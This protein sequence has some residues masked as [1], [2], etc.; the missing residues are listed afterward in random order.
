MFRLPRNNSLRRGFTLIEAI[1]SVALLVVLSGITVYGMIFHA[2]TAKSNLVR[3]RIAE[4]S[5]KFID[6]AQIAALDATI[7]RIDSGPAGAGT[8]LTIGKPDPDNVGSVIYKQY[9]YLDTDGNP[10]TINDN[11]I[12]E[13]DTNTPNAT[14]GK[15]LVEYCYPVTGTRIFTQDA[16]SLRPLFNINL[17]VGDR[18]FPA[19]NADNAF[20]GPGYQAF[21]IQTSIAQL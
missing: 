7:I 1:V 4:Q 13:R 12:V 15:L 5:R 2:R 8:V 14:T 17:R 10:A 6:F 20:T 11:R 3:E 16:K 9:A 18:T 21:Q 19:N